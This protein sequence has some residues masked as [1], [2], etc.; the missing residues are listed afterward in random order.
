[1]SKASDLLEDLEFIRWVKF[2]NTELDNFW[3]SWMAANPERVKDVMLAREIILGL[4]FPSK[5]PSKELKQEVFAN[6]L[7][8]QEMSSMKESPELDFSPNQ[9]WYANRI[10]GKISAILA[11]A[12]LLTILF[13]SL[14]GEDS[15]G[16]NQVKTKWLVKSTHKGEKLNFRLPDQTIVWLNSGSSLR[17][18]E[19]FDSTVR[20]VEL[21][22]EGFFEVSENP[23][24]PFQVLTNGLLTTALGTSFNINHSSR[25]TV[26]IAL[27]SGKVAV[28]HQKDSISYLL[29]PG[30]ALA[31]QNAEHQAE[32]NVFDLDTE[33]GWKSGKLI[34]NNASFRQVTKKLQKWYG[35]DIDVVGAPKSD[36]EFNGKFENQT[37]ENVLKSMSNIENFSYQLSN[38]HIVLKF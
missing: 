8:E 34:F 19:S 16:Q 29:K 36:W 38:K 23:N 21:E 17:Y 14:K 9:G 32:I 7:R 33:V 10:F 2:P 11:V 6:L 26:K 27:V 37:L 12:V 22:G 20:L 28:Q 18:P 15:S 4:Q 35:V 1:M 30:L 5:L 25:E 3:K 13:L 31:Y 24:Q